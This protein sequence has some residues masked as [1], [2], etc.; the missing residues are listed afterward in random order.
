MT[1]YTVP[2]PPK[3]LRET[4]CVAQA[5]LAALGR[6]RPNYNDGGPLTTHTARLEL[7]IRECDRH[8]PL[9]PDG[10]HDDRH[11]PTCGC[12]DLQPEGSRARARIQEQA[13]L[14][15]EDTSELLIEALETLA[16]TYGQAGVLRTARKLWPSAAT[17]GSPGERF[18]Q[19]K[20]YA[21][22]HGLQHVALTPPTQ[23]PPRPPGDD[24][25]AGHPPRQL[26]GDPLHHR[27]TWLRALFHRKDP[28]R[29]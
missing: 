13:G 27:R 21:D 29:P 6:T 14:P 20:A 12:A 19:W 17:S 4:L 15:L 26:L 1:A 25:R 9:G 11:T 18:D 28:H 10:K 22:A 5:A 16:A 24:P 23:P 8:R 3:M 7:L 2:V